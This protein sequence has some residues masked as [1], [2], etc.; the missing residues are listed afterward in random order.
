MS[1]GIK[2][3]H[4]RALSPQPEIHRLGPEFVRWPSGLMQ[5][6]IRV[7]NLAQ[8]LG[9]PCVDFVFTAP[10]R[11]SGSPSVWM[12]SPAGVIN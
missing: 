7:L 8:I 5:I 4:D 12:P 6:P 1:G 2:R 11:S 10:I 3:Q 9:Q